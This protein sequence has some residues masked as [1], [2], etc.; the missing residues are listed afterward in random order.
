MA[1]DN[2]AKRPPSW[3]ARILAWALPAELKAPVLGDLSE[4]YGQRVSTGSRWRA[5]AWYC[6]QAL[7]SAMIFLWSFKRGVLMFLFSVMAF[8][9]L[10]LMAMTGAGE[11]TMYIDVP[12]AMLVVLPALLFGVAATSWQDIRQTLAVLVSG[13]TGIDP[14]RCERG[15]RVMAVIGNS[16]VLLGIVASLIG[17]VK[18]AVDFGSGQV[19]ESLDVMLAVLLLTLLY[20]V[21]LKVLC[22]VADIRLQSLSA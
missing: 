6:R 19:T 10:T 12:S 15:R 16:A 21:M 7:G 1:R 9:G 14:A 4:E 11:L 18:I 17:L 22:Y 20:G 5:V 3:P 8:F 13:E 2:R